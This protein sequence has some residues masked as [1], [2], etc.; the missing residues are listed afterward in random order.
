MTIVQA[1]ENEVISFI[2]RYPYTKN[3][4]CM[5]E[6]SLTLFTTD[7]NNQITAFLS[8]FFREIPAPRN[9][10]TEC[11]IN[12]I[13]VIDTALQGSGIGSMLVQEII[14]YAKSKGVLQVRAYC[15]IHNVTSHMLWQKNGFGIS[16]GKNA[17][18]SI[19]GSF[20]TFRIQ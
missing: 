4:M 20:V 16:P 8:A 18:G 3:V 12:V 2:E 10:K 15:D 14:R 1:T 5:G 17:D 7:D 11:F 19:F 6:D 9:G 13:D